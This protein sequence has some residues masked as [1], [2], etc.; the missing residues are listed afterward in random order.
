VKEYRI[1]S[2]SESD[3]Q[4]EPMYWSN[5]WGWTSFEYSDS[6]TQ[7]EKDKFHLPSIG[8]PDAKWVKDSKI[9]L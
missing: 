6:F 3:R 5:T 4:G 8:V 7:E 9:S 2:Q 1:F